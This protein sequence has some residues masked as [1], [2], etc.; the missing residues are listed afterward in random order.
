VFDNRSTRVRLV[1]ARFRIE[2]K[3]FPGGVSASLSRQ[4]RPRFIPHPPDATKHHE[5]SRDRLLLHFTPFRYW[6][7]ARQA[8]TPASAS[9]ETL[10]DSLASAAA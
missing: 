5:H 9:P 7:P 6:K 1:P 2:E 3:A 4:A 8:K 10:A